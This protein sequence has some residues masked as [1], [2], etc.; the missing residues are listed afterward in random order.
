MQQVA[1]EKSQIP[2]TES[3][4]ET[5]LL[6]VSKHTPVIEHRGKDSLRRRQGTQNAEIQ[7]LMED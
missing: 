6:E 7:S 1:V 2:Q 3:A 4:V 5:H